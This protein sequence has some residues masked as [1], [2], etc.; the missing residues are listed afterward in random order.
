VLLSDEP[1]LVDDLQAETRFT[2]TA[3]LLD[4]GV[5][6]SVS[7]RVG[8]REKPFGVLGAHAR[9]RRRFSNDHVRFL[10]A[11]AGI[12]GTSLQ[13]I[14]AEEEVHALNLEL[15]QRVAE[16]TRELRSANAELESFA[17]S[18]SH[19]LRA[20]VRAVAGFS[21]VVLSEYGGLIDDR[22]R[23][24]LARMRAAAQRMGSMIDVLLAL[25]RV[26][27]EQLRRVQVDASELVR[28]IVGELR[29]AEPG[30]P[31]ET[32]VA[33]DLVV[34]ADRALLRIVFENLLSNAWKFTAT[35]EPARIEVGSALEGGEQ[36]FFVRDNGVGFE[37]DY[38]D[39]LFRPF[40]RL[41]RVD[42]F[43]GAGIG[44]ATVARIVSRHGGRVWAS[45]K[46]GHGACFSFT[47]GE[48]TPAT[49][50]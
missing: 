4:S 10:E 9:R 28:E 18:V 48:E 22:G 49:A 23:D 31:V 47:L 20:P 46:P 44:L 16:R 41:H 17:S 37:M 29:E 24:Y 11:V 43:P 30:R 7:V 42:E 50:S 38:V 1:V 35:T 45:G 32:V 39:Q 34:F 13:R 33:D 40:Q 5:V 19:D 27:R 26:S 36:A 25:S 3:L 2:P 12:L 8:P 15:E 14:E 21:E 6:S